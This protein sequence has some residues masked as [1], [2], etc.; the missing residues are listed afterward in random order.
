MK[1]LLCIPVLIASIGLPGLSNTIYSQVLQL[2]PNQPSGLNYASGG[3]ING[4][5]MGL[6]HEFNGNVY[7]GYAN[8]LYKYDGTSFTLL[9]DPADHALVPSDYAFVNFSGKMFMPFIT[10]NGNPWNT[11]ELFSYDGSSLTHIPKPAIPNFPVYDP[12]GG[13][14]GYFGILNGDL[15]LRFI[16][17]NPGAIFR[18]DG[19]NFTHIADSTCYNSNGGPFIHY[20]TKTYLSR[21][22]NCSGIYGLYE[23][24][25][26]SSALIPN[27]PL[28]TNLN[29]GFQGQAI[30]YN[31]KLY[32]RYRNNSNLFQL[33][34]FDGTGLTLIPNPPNHSNAQRGYM[35]SPCIYNGKLYLHYRS[36]GQHN[37]LF[38]FDGTNL[39]AVPNP[40]NNFATYG[41]MGENSPPI[42]YNGKMYIGYSDYTTTTVYHLYEFD[43][44]TFTHIPSPPNHD[45]MGRGYYGV[46][47]VFNA[48]LYLPFISNADS[49]LLYTLSGTTVQGPAAPSNLTAT[50][51]NSIQLNWQD[52]STDEDGFH[53]DYAL[54]A[55]GPW[56][57]IADL[58][59]NTTSYLH[60]GGLTNGVEY[61]YRVRAYNSN[62][63]SAYSNVASAI[64]GALGNSQV[65]DGDYSIR[66]Y[67][68]PVSDYLSVSIQGDMPSGGLSLRIINLIG[69][70]VGEYL[71][72]N[73]ITKIEV[74]DMPSGIYI[75]C[76][77]TKSQLHSVGKL[78]IE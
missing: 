52:N 42:V 69:Q 28:H 34:E 10:T 43:G 49:F 4:T 15:Y 75:Y 33:Y 8:D 23:F 29:T 9:T 74:N 31:G 2:V 55:A 66:I 13:Y 38:E 24:N 62:G 59:A 77:S 58:G 39:T 65:Q 60:T 78:R 25:G 7:L 19:T 73:H 53:V 41:M 6:P 50:P 57:Q 70:I 45:A 54:S 46:P 35:G 26:T 40:P 56:T 68:N 14:G 1:R 71:I 27:P 32:L 22:D 30:E 72:D 12:N 61:F 5:P 63:T 3:S 64:E 20:N 18:Y 44:T 51:V 67:P 76:L 16:H 17:P 37:Q 36:N 11:R 47:F 48:S 21:Y